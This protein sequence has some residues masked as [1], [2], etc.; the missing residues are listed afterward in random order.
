M[1]TKFDRFHPS[2][3]ESWGSAIVFLFLFRTPAVHS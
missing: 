1:P 2:F 3:R